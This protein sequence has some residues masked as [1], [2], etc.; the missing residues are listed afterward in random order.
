MRGLG[1]GSVVACVLLA[2]SAVGAYDLTGRWRS[3][4]GN[5]SLVRQVDN[6]VYWFVDDSPRVQNVFVGTLRGNLITGEWADLPGNRLL[7]AGTITLTVE[8]NDRMVKSSESEAYGASVW[9]REGTG[10]SSDC[11]SGTSFRR[12]PGMAIKDHNKKTLRNTSVEACKRACIEAEQEY[13]FCCRS[14]DYKDGDCFLQEVDTSTEKLI[15]SKAD[16]ACY[17]ERQ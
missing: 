13:G 6:R 17:Y 8:S 12:H 7:N 15:K 14:I 5:I 4:T 2:A 3:D 11:P 1:T 16:N 9:T 10:G